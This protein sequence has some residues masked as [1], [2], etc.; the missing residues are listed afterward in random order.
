MLD[1][2]PVKLKDFKGR[3]DRG[4]HE[5]CPPDHFI[6]SKN[7]I[8]LESGV[9]TR[10]GTVLD[11]NLS[12]SFSTIRRVYRYERTGEAV[13]FLI[14]DASGNI[15]DTLN[16]GSPI[17]S[18]PAMTDFA[19]ITLYNRAY[20][21]PHDG[22]RGLSGQYLYVYEGTGTARQAAGAAPT[23]FTLGVATGASG[24]IE[25]GKHLFGVAFETAS[26]FI[27][28]PGPDTFTE[29][30]APG[31]KAVNITAIPI[32][33]AGTVSRHLVATKKLASTYVGDEDNQEFF[34]IPN[35]EIP[36]NVDTTFNGISFYDSELQSSCD[37]LLDQLEEI[38]AGTFLAT[39]NGRL[40]I[41]GENANEH[42]VRISPVADP[43]SF[44]EVDG[45][46]EVG[47]GDKGGAVKNA[48]EDRGQL[49]IMKD[50]RTY[51]TVDSGPFI[52]AWK[53]NSIDANIGTG[54]HGIS[55]FN[56]AAGHSAENFIFATRSGLRIFD[57]AFTNRE[58]SWKIED[59][60]KR[61]N[62][63]K[64]DLVQVIVDTI[65]RRIYVNVP[66]DGADNPSHV[67]VCDY[68]SGL[69]WDTVKWDIWN[70]PDTVQS[71]M[72][73][74]D[75]DE[76]PVFKFSP[77]NAGKIYAL[78]PDST[79]DYSSL[80]DSYFETGYIIPSEDESI[81]HYG[82][83]KLRAIGSGS[84]ELRVS[85]QSDGL[86]SNPS[87]LALSASPSRSLFRKINFQNERARFRF[88]AGSVNHWFEVHTVIIFCKELWK[89][90]P[91]E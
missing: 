86:V 71:I 19:M 80:I 81:N 66:L 67:L 37:Y 49:F 85:G 58:L 13:R 45:Y 41:G 90:I 12:A 25:A 46:L 40:C 11:E 82:G 33:P 56:D 84:L 34:F 14:L 55:S 15:W 59:I 22:N 1:H 3:W 79:N 48:V 52:N 16:I 43:E 69:S 7:I 74:V 53:A 91:G 20:I 5:S 77:H 26:G 28:R 61:I 36:N 23:G 44:S 17:L 73:D 54:P 70:F 87:S 60:W 9:R 21:S 89:S 63:T 32:G 38:P 62:V 18:I 27:T 64:F 51:Q 72:L 57:G 39:Y 24:R 8:F 29:Y 50:A 47:P 4:E 10:P 35:G 75:D 76:I 83:I 6:D 42:V 68:K 30:T 88:R 78:D 65:A 31:S 2:I